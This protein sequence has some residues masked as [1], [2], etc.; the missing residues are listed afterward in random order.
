[1]N[2]LDERHCGAFIDAACAADDAV[3]KDT[4]VLRVLVEENDDVLLFRK[5]LRDEDGK[6]WLI[7]SSIQRNSNFIQAK[8]FE[9]F[10][11]YVT[12]CL[13]RAVSTGPDESER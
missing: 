5:V 12:N 2:A 7:C 6:M 3:G 1:M 4:D 8:G 13:R 10:R 9:T 11:D